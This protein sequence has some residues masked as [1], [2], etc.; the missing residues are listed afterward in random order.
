MKSSLLLQTKF[1]IPRHSPEW[2]ARPR[3]IEYLYKN[4]HKRL[5]LISTPAGYGKTT[6]LAEFTRTVEGNIAWYKLDSSDNDPSIFVSCLVAA[7]RK[8]METDKL[9]NQSSFGEATLAV[10]DNLENE[11]VGYQQILTVFINELFEVIEDDWTIILDDYHIITNVVIHKLISYLLENAPPGFQLIISTR[12]DLPIQLARLRAL[13]VMAELRAKDLRFTQQEIK[14]WFLKL[15]PNLS[16]DSLITLNQKTGGWAAALQI[17]LSSIQ[18]EDKNEA[19]QFIENIS[20]THRYIYDY[21][22]AE[23]FKRLTPDM[24]NFLLS[25]SI[26][27][28]MN[29]EICDVLLERH[30]SYMILSKLESANLCVVNTS[31]QNKWYTY[32][33]LFREFLIDKLKRE[34]TNLFA[35]LECKAGKYYENQSEWDRAFSYFVAIDKQEKAAQILEKFAQKF[36]EHGRVE[37]INRYLA[38]LNEETLSAHPELLLQRGN[39]LRRLGEAGT[40][41][42]NYEDAHWGFERV[43][44]RAGVCRALTRLAEMHYSQGHY[45]KARELAAEALA[46]ATSDDHAE[47]ARALMSLAKSVG[48]LVGM[49]EGQSLA[50]QAVQEALIAGDLVSPVIKASLLQSLGQICWW[51]GDPQASIQYCQDALNSI[52]EKLSPIAAKAH[53]TLAS[54]YL[55]R[56]DIETAL[57]HA[58]QGLEIAQVLHIVELLPSAYAVLGN[59]LT[60]LGDF[61]RAENSLRQAMEIAER[62]GIASYERVMATGYLAYNLA[63]Q[64]RLDEAKQLIESALWPYTGHPASYDVYVSKSVLADIALGKDELAKAEQYYL[65]LLEIG[66]KRQFRIPLG[67]VYFGLAYIYLITNRKNEGIAYAHKSIELIESTRSFQ[68]YL[69]QG[70]RSQV[71]CNALLASGYDSSFVRKVLKNVVLETQKL[72]QIKIADNKVVIVETLGKY[73]V[74]VNGQEITQERWVS[75]KARDLL[76]YF[77]T[78]RGERI[79]V[80][81]VFDALWHDH[82][83]RGKA[84]FHT[85]LSR[86]RKALRGEESTSKFILVEAGEYWLDVARF[87]LDVDEFKV[88]LKQAHTINKPE[89]AIG[90]YLR[91]LD[92]Y[93]GEYL[94]NLFYDWVFPERRHLAQLYLSLI[95]ETAE[96]YLSLGEYDHAIELTRR[97][98]IEDPLSEEAYQKAMKAYAKLGRQADV[99]RNYQL[100]QE[101]LADELGVKPTN[102]TQELFQYLTG[103]SPH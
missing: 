69:D 17:I 61:V 86:L 40:A 45:R 25:T 94:T 19:E 36:V 38:E 76:A 2:L 51:H 103:K 56:G 14:D 52:S 50:E 77:V 100:L 12:V 101:H 78:F 81:R 71:V 43:G 46:Q 98:I 8:M 28:Q 24:Q 92:L 54:P 11:P 4:R 85:A 41:V 22:A 34:K 80:D 96:I 58:E 55:Y 39:V 23:V 15:I 10:L 49:E 97:A 48:F 90:W 89:V 57:H 35:E 21:L 88:A 7:F 3:L 53:I 99:I 66:L 72:P 32:H 87:S 62:L 74:V 73:Q 82:T 60:R 102:P 29:S 9:D 83:G 95:N 26:L 42:A 68:L 70:I 27:N 44:N 1:L 91:A 13:G 20:G 63:E 5:I 67:M 16:E 37:A 75:T 65:S 30:D 64:G 33:Q 18:Y 6:L 79:L 59:V 31:E 84:A 93:K 47:R